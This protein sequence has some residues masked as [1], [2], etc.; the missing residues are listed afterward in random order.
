MLDG[1]RSISELLEN[2]RRLGIPTTIDS[3]DKFF[4]QLE[5][6]GLLGAGA[7]EAP[8]T[9]ATRAQWDS[10]VRSL[11]QSGIRLLRMGKHDEAAG[12]FEALLQEDP[13]NVEARELLAMASQPNVESAPPPSP[14]ASQLAPPASIPQTPPVMPAPSTSMRT[15]LIAVGAVACI[16]IAA[17]V[18]IV[19]RMTTQSS[20]PPVAAVV[21]TPAAV[22][23]PQTPPAVTERAAP[24]PVATERSGQELQR[25]V[26]PTEAAGDK[27]AA[28]ERVAAAEPANDTTNDDAAPS[29]QPDRSRT[30]AKTKREPVRLVAP[31]DG[32]I[33]SYLRRARNVRKGE[34]LFSIKKA[35][36]REKIEKLSAKVVELTELAKQDEVYAPF[37]DDARKKLAAARTVRTMPVTAPRAGKATPRVKNGV[38]IDAG[39]L[40]VVI[41]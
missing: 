35:G 18:W 16:A 14:I 25:P 33:K 30:V 29:E 8:T 28:P 4:L 32:V 27:P 19:A 24:A 26:A 15:A 13:N 36:N 11:F 31:S 22:A 37:L 40:L 41:E 20:T 39:A 17:M 6:D 9:W 5:R 23:P 1:K 21:S 2:C 7:S 38:R 10:S 34:K 12:Y 3:L